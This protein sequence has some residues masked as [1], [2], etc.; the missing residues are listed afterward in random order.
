MPMNIPGYDRASLP[1][2]LYMWQPEPTMERLGGLV[3]C[4][5]KNGQSAPRCLLATRFRAAALG[6]IHCGLAT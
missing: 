5:A 3:C 4:K 2:F 1:T 6:P